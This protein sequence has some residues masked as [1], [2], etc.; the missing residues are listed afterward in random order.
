M[1]WSQA[2]CA[3]AMFLM[4]IGCLIY[5]TRS[6]SGQARTPWSYF[7]PKK[8]VLGPAPGPR[9]TVI[10]GVIGITVGTIAVVGGIGLLIVS[11]I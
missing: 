1:L 2:G 8:P 3:S 9:E 11:L 6:L 10:A 5:G 7:M 4:G